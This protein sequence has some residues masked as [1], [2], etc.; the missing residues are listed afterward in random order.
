MAVELQSEKYS[1][2]ELDQLLVVGRTFGLNYDKARAVVLERIGTGGKT[3]VF[4][5]GGHQDAV[6]ISMKVIHYSL[7]WLGPMDQGF[8]EGCK[9]NYES[10]KASQKT[11]S[12]SE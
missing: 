3:I 1:L 4:H 12:D 9:D 2:D 5:Y 8:L 7:G 11:E 10:F 6:E